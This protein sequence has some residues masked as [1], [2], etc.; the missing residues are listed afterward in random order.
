MYQGQKQH[1]KKSQRYSKSKTDDC[2]EPVE[3]EILVLY[4]CCTFTLPVLY[5][6]INKYSMRNILY[7]VKAGLSSRDLCHQ[8]YP[9]TKMFNA[10]VWGKIKGEKSPLLGLKVQRVCKGLYQKKR[11]ILRKMCCNF[12]LLILIAIT[13]FYTCK[14]SKYN[15]AYQFIAHRFALHIHCVAYIEPTLCVHFWQELEDPGTNVAGYS[16]SHKR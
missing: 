5:F 3:S 16:V 13:Q 14:T 2:W 9:T 12:L 4:L 11:Y 8:T 1:D 15:K 6:R 7:H 10:Q